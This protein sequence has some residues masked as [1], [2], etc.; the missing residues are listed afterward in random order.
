MLK[1]FESGKRIDGRALDEFRPIEVQRNIS[2]TAEGSCKIKVGDCEVIVGTKLEVGTPY[3]DTPDEGS[4]MVNVEM[5]PMSHPTFEPGPPGIDAIESARVI[6]K[7][8]RESHALDV[9]KLCIKKGEKIWMVIIDVCPINFDGNLIDIGGIGALVAL[10]ETIMPSLTEDM[11]P[12]YKN[13]S[14]EKLHLHDLPIPITVYK[15][16]DYLVIDPTFEEQK[17]ASARLTVI[18]TQDDKICALQKGEEEPLTIETV[19]KMTDLAL[20]CA[21]QIRQQL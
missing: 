3:P 1:I 16:G 10:Q 13:P 6:D 7:S 21:K 20:K 18:C 12:D 17:F 5:L 2:K 8:F 4:M 19:E 14:G 11:Q 15:I 9:K